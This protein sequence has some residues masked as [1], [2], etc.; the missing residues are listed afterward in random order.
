ML[1]SFFSPSATPTATC[2]LSPSCCEYTGAQ[3]TDENRDSI[4]ACL[5]AITKTLCLRGSCLREGADP[6][7]F[8]RYISP[9]FKRSSPQLLVFQHVGCLEI[10]S[11]GVFVN[12]CDITPI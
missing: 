11:V 5:L 3:I 8:T 2:V 4:S 9:R 10:Q 7:F 6:G 12:D 1:E